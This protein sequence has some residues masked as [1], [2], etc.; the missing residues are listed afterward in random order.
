MTA[1]VAGSVAER[2][3]RWIRERPELEWLIWKNPLLVAGSLTPEYTL[4]IEQEILGF[5]KW[6]WR[7]WRTYLR[8]RLF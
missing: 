4:D 2:L 3:E 7:I 1:G 6:L 5:F 8:R